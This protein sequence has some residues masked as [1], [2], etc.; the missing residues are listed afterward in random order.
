MN[1]KDTINF[2]ALKHAVCYRIFCP[3]CEHAMMD[4]N[5]AVL[6]S[7]W[8]GDTCA[9][10]KVMCAPCYDAMAD[11]IKLHVSD[12]LTLEVTDGR[13]YTRKGMRKIQRVKKSVNNS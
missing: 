6:I 1:M 7:I 10:S 11:Q 4:V 5:H 3:K 13:T 8:Q 2:N 12:N 9:M